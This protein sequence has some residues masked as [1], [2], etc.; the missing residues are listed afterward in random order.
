[1]DCDILINIGSLCS[2]GG[3]RQCTTD[4]RRH[5]ATCLA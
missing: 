3:P 4:D 2:Y 1:M 5:T